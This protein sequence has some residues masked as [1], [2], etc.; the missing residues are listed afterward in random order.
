MKATQWKNCRYIPTRLHTA[1]DAS[2][3]GLLHELSHS[4]SSE[5]SLQPAVASPPVQF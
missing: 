2:S 1:L 4:W 3:S 5:F